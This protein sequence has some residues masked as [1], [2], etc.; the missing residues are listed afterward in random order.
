VAKFP[1][2][3]FAAAENM[4]KRQKGLKGRTRQNQYRA[5]VDV[6]RPTLWQYHLDRLNQNVHRSEMVVELERQD[7][8]VIHP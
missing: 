1:Q 6:R 2:V 8:R 3:G 7:L 5:M 4:C